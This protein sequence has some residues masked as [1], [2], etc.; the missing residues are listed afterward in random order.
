M[1]SRQAV[2]K[3]CISVEPSLVVTTHWDPLVQ[4]TIFAVVLDRLKTAWLPGCLADDED[5]LVYG[6]W[7]AN[8][9]KTG[10]KAT[11]QSSVV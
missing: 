10:Q 7:V 11:W 5:A 1:Q 3:S 9:T 6:Q 4:F 8:H 2:V